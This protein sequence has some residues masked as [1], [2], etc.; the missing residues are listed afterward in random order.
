VILRGATCQIFVIET[1]QLTKMFRDRKRGEVR[2]VDGIARKRKCC[3]KFAQ[4][5]RNKFNTFQ[6]PDSA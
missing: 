1:H 4:L 6:H 3:A 2:A 5:L